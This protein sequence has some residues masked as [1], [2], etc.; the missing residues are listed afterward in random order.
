MSRAGWRFG[1]LATVVA[2]GV[3]GECCN[4]LVA[5]VPS[6]PTALS[7]EELLDTKVYNASKY[8]QE[9]GEAPSS[10]VVIS[11]EQSENTATRT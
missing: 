4:L 7:L 6:N 8:E 1:I 9:V 2:I 3:L 10:I 5:Q 11:A